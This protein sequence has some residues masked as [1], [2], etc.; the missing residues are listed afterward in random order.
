MPPA[1]A[2]LSPAA[3]VVVARDITAHSTQ[4]VQGFVEQ[5]G[6]EVTWPGHHAK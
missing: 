5:E 2:R 4:V 1:T 6:G 3:N